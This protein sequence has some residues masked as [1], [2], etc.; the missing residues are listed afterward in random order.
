MKYLRISVITDLSLLDSSVIGGFCGS[1]YECH[2]TVPHTLLGLC[3]IAR[4]FFRIPAWL[5]CEILRWKK[6]RVVECR[7]FVICVAI[8][9]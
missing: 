6:L 5:L 3:D 2:R 8:N 7:V 1:V 4:L 9:H